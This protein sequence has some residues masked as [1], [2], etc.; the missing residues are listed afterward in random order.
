MVSLFAISIKV[1]REYQ[2]LVVFF[3]GRFQ[4]VKKP[5]LR[6]IIPGIQQAVRVDLRVITMDVPSQDVISKDNVTIRVN[7]V[8]YFRVV[9]PE[10]AIIQVED[11]FNATSQLAQTTLR[12]V[13]GQHELDEMLSEREKVNADLQEIIEPTVG[14]A[15]DQ[16][17]CRPFINGHQINCLKRDN[18]E[19]CGR[20]R[21]HILAG[22]KPVPEGW[23]AT[24]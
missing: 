10:K 6:L 21:S 20:A 16:P 19:Q 15:H 11:Y 5:G 7:A 8:L 4:T 9:E 13:L 3:L 1:V 24:G 17:L 18:D 14:A 2:R 12:S 23:P 22:A